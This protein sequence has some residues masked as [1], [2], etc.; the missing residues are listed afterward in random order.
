MY[1]KA[2]QREEQASQ[3][4]LRK[5]KPLMLI[6]VKQGKNF[7]ACCVAGRKV[8]DTFLSI[9]LRLIDKSCYCFTD[10]F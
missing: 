2:K 1:R 10:V 5:T 4:L 6:L 7:H 3:I 9:E 8:F